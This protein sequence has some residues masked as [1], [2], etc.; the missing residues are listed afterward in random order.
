MGY[1]RS[2]G[3]WEET[4]LAFQQKHEASAEFVAP[5]LEEIVRR[6]GLAEL[7]GSLTE[8]EH[9]FFLALLLNV[10]SRVDILRLVTQRFPASPVETILRWAEE[11]SLDAEFPAE[12]GV[13]SEQQPAVFLAALRYFLGAGESVA[14][15]IRY[16]YLR[17]T[18]SDCAARL[19]SRI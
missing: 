19:P 8:I 10:P 18:S 9:R 7:R 11:L 4:L 14:S 12:L 3:K 16:R 17:R 15:L 13:P 1:L 6:D 5:T 2:L